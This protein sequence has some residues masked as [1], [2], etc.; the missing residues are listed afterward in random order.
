MPK[1]SFDFLVGKH[2][3]DFSDSEYP[4]AQEICKAAHSGSLKEINQLLNGVAPAGIDE[5]RLSVST[6]LPCAASATYRVP[7][8]CDATTRCRRGCRARS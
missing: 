4:F 2:T 8:A 6:A 5:Y 7:C 3:V 1:M